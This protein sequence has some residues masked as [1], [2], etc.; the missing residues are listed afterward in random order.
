MSKES[1]RAQAIVD[2]DQHDSSCGKSLSVRE[3]SGTT[4]KSSAVDPYHDRK[5]GILLLRRCP[6]I[7]IETILTLGPAV[8]LLTAGLCTGVS[9]AVH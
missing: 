6:D 7:E 9:K 5:P 2:R 1:Q 3:A 4:C 8:T